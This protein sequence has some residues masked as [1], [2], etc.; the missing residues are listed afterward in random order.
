MIIPWDVINTMGFNTSPT[1][2]LDISRDFRKFIGRNL[3]SPIG[4]HGFF[5]LTIASCDVE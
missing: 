1:S 5:D 3:A 4:F 2:F